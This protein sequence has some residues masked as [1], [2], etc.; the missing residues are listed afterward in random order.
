MA[1]YASRVRLDIARWVERGLVDQT[2]AQALLRDV[3]ENDRRS[4]SFGAILMIMAALLFAAALLLLVA[5]NWEAFPRLLRVGVLFATMAGCYVGGAVL[6]TRDHSAIAEGLWLIGAA[7]LGGSI[8]LIGQMYHLSGDEASAV[9]TWCLGTALAAAALRSGPL[10]LAAAGI[11]FFWMVSEGFDFW[12][13]TPFPHLYLALALVVWLVSYWTRSALTRHFLILSVLFHFFLLALDI[14]QGVTIGLAMAA[15]SALAFAAA[16]LAPALVER[17]L[18][19]N[20][21]LPL[22]AL[23]GF[24]TGATMVQFNLYDHGPTIVAASAIVFAA[25][26]AAL[27][28]EGRESRGLRWIAYLGFTGQLCFVY[29]AMVGSM[30]GTAGLFLASGLVLAIIAFIIIRIEKRMATPP[31][32]AEAT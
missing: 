20:G 2:T 23:I 3:E 16:V 5:A 7:A 21:R 9:M 10:T 32:R 19:L 25:I 6:K 27:L 30:L 12:S 29:V 1:S 11:G 17:L 13:N 31:L 15:I 26:A 8:A 28:L 24:L 22:H 18:A 14:D 4:I